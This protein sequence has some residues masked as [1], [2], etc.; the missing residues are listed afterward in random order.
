[1]DL[2]E[3]KEQLPISFLTDFVSRGWD[4]VG[5]LK[6]TINSIKETFSGT[7]KVEEILQPL[8]DA[9][10]VCIGQLELH[11]QNKDYIEMPDLKAADETKAVTESVQ[12]AAKQPQQATTTGSGDKAKAA[13]KEEFKQPNAYDTLKLTKTEFK[14]LLDSNNFG[15]DDS[16]EIGDCYEG[17]GCD[18]YKDP[19][20]STLYLANSDTDEKTGKK[21]YRLFSLYNYES[22]QDQGN[23]DEDYDSIDSLLA[24]IKDLNLDNYY[25][26]IAG[27]VLRNTANQE[28]IDSKPWAENKQQS[29]TTGSAA[30]D[31]AFNLD[32]DNPASDAAPLTDADL[33]PDNTPQKAD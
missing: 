13:L 1:M 30:N 19:Y 2:K 4:Q 18:E 7:K 12:N 15:R 16:L 31:N 23:F 11:M 24:A 21:T 29:D 32:F 6:E 28:V 14:D 22:G 5:Q 27:Y 3:S 33:Y 25:I 26:E 8:V 10:L 20:V 9:Y 17:R